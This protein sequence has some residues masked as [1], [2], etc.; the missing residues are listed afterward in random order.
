MTVDYHKFNQV[1]TAT[2]AA[3]P[4]VVSL[5][6]QINTSPG[7]QYTA[8]DL[9]NVFSSIPISKEHQNHFVLSCQG[10]Q[11]IITV[12]PHWYINSPILCHNLVFRDLNNLSLPQDIMPAHYNDDIVMTRFSKQDRTIQNLLISYLHIRGWKT[13]P[14]KIQGTLTSMKFRGVQWYEAWQD[15]PSKVKNKLLHLISPTTKKEAQHLVGFFRFQRQQH[16]PHLGVLL[17]LIY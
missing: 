16:I 14:A 8:I 5:F 13:D 1:I 9:V 3:V 11:C 2:A 6:E 17:W 4:D 10:Q 15:I 12:L 7:T